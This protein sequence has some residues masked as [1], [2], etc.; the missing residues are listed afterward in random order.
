M[1]LIAIGSAKSLL[2]DLVTHATSAEKPSKWFASFSSA[3][4]VTNKGKY[5]L[6]TLCSLNFVSN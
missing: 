2:P 5:A 1:G 6:L 4:L 3:A